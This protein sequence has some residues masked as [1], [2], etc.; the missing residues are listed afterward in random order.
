MV[1]DGPAQEG[2]RNHG[3]ARERRSMTLKELATVIVEG[4]AKGEPERPSQFSLSRLLVYVG[5]AL[6]EAIRDERDQCARVVEKHT[7]RA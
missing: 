1:G 6:D 2:E 7:D 3:H 5:L 4:W